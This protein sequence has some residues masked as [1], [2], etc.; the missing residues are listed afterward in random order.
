MLNRIK[1]ENIKN[2]ISARNVFVALGISLVFFIAIRCPTDPDM[3]W[4]LQDGKYLI[5]H[6]FKVAR[7]DIFSYTMP[8]FPLIMHEWTTDI[9]MEKF[10]ETTN[11]FFLSVL[12][13]LIT[14]LAFLLV[15]WGTPAKIEYKVIAAILGTIASVPVLGVRPQMLSLLGLASVVYII[16]RFRRSHSSN[17]IYWLPLIFAV[18]VNIH[19]GFAVGLFFI[20]L[21]CAVEIFKLAASYLFRKIGR[22]RIFTL[23]HGIS[24]GCVSL[25]ERLVKNSIPLRSVSKMII[26]FFVSFLATL[27][28]PYGWRVYIEVFTTAMDSYAKANIN[29]WFPV[30]VANPMSYQFI[31]YLSLLA[32]LLLFSYR[33]TDYTYLTIALAFLYL[34]FSSWR[35]MP[36]FLIVSTPLWI[37]ITEGIA[38]SELLKVVRKKWFLA[39]MALSVFLIAQQKMTKVIP[40]NFSLERLAGDG[41]YP[42]GAVDYLKKNPIEGRMFNEYNW[43]GYLIWQYPEKKVFIDGRMPSWKMGDQRIFEEFNEMFKYEKNWQDVLKKYDV[44]FTLIYNNA[45]NR[46]MFSNSG[47]KEVYHDDLSIIFVRPEN[48]K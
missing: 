47:W 30:T 20:G 37:S 45:P 48:Q 7:Q 31:I 22:I 2:Y 6:N 17:I 16:F 32:L 15:S 43:G 33:K 1:F 19:G 44:G 23:Y 8:D 24:T 13:A 25:A 12:F 28:N 46:A 9:F 42:L 36:L 27:L 4:H 41:N 21:F 29:E 34:G 10:L 35:H 3:G 39:F 11:F 40:Y 26:V 18:W 14:T 38:G 5:E